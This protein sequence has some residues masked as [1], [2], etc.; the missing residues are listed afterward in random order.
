MNFTNDIKD[1]MFKI[2]VSDVTIYMHMHFKSTMWKANN[3]DLLSLFSYCILLYII[4]IYFV[5][6]ESNRIAMYLDKKAD[7]DQ[8]S[9]S[10]LFIIR[11]AMLK[12]QLLDNNVSE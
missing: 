6:A 10:A 4:I 11:H 8:L 5:T 1:I 12:H 2:D 3:L 7:Q 9:E